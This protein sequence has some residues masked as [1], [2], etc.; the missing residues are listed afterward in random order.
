M[1]GLGIGSVAD[2]KRPDSISLSFSQMRDIPVGER[3]E[4]RTEYGDTLRGYFLGIKNFSDEKNSGI[5]E[6]SVKLRLGIA[7]E[8]GKRLYSE[9]EIAE[10][11]IF[12]EKNMRLKGF[13]VGLAI[14]VIVVAAVISSWKFSPNLHLKFY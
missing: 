10:A 13:L 1:I 7:G 11:L 6:D 2:A 3:I 5:S 9:D 12:P 8:F 4:L 14:D